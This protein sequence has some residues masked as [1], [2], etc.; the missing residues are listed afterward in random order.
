M[1]MLMPITVQLPMLL[2]VARNSVRLSELDTPGKRNKLK[3]EVILVWKVYCIE[4]NFSN[5][6]NEL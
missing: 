4:L 2:V 5:V 6:Q 1:E 3:T